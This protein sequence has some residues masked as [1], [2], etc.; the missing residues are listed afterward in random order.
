MRKIRLDDSCLNHL[1]NTPLGFTRKS[2]YIHNSEKSHAKNIMYFADM[3]FVRTWRNLYRYA[4]GSSTAW[5][6]HV[7]VIRILLY[8]C[9]RLSIF[10]DCWR[11]ETM[12]RR[13]TK[14]SGL[15]TPPTRTRQNCLVL[16]ALAVWT[17]YS[18]LWLLSCTPPSL[19]GPVLRHRHVIV[20]WPSSANHFSVSQ[21]QRRCFFNNVDRR[22]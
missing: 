15:F 13:H 18:C 11:S 4:T 12:R 19:T 6:D 14:S 5:L 20:Y 21:I 10:I 9:R 7:I 16:S 22:H 8:C 2:L 1:T 3:G 17:S